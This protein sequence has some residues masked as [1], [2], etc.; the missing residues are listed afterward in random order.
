M[1]WLDAITDS[2]DMSLSKLWE[3]VM[4]RE[5]WRAAVHEALQVPKSQTLL[6]DWTNWTN[7]LCKTHG[8]H[9]EL[10]QED[11]FQ[12]F[13]GGPVVKNPP[14]NGGEAEVW[15]LVEE[16]RI[17]MPRGNWTLMWQLD[18]PRATTIEPTHLPAHHN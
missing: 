3:F 7:K 8:W 9:T 6:N 16:L 17:H 15:S 13:P 10:N 18:S 1:R 4:D 2:M 11:A 5:A 12:N 14:S